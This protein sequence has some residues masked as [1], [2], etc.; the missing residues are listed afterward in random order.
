MVNS[1]ILYRGNRFLSAQK[2]YKQFVLSLLEWFS[3]E[4]RD[5]PWRH[6]Y[7]PYQVW[8]SEVMLQQTQMDRV[9][10]YFN[11]WMQIFPDI[12]TLADASEQR[13]LKTWGRRST[14]TPEF[15][16]HTLAIHNGNKFIP[17]YISE[18]MVGHKL[19][20]FSPT[21]TYRGH[22]DKEKSSRIR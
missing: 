4:Q 2:E 13:V 5:L 14:I 9:V 17:V 19:G 7:D 21:R 11:N 8:I 12:Q 22:R 16:G 6:T 15:V 3:E 10:N 20:E 1:L 18:N